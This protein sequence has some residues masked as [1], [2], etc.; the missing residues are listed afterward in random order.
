MMRSEYLG[1]IYT[2]VG[3]LINWLLGIKEVFTRLLY[4]T[5]VYICDLYHLC[6]WVPRGLRIAH[7]LKQ[8][9]FIECLPYAERGKGFASVLL[10]RRLPSLVASSPP[11]PPPVPLLPF[12]TD[13]GV[14]NS[15]LQVPGPDPSSRR[16]CG[17]ATLLSPSF[18]H[19]G[20]KR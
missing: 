5:P 17:R 1:P 18:L 3:F 15:F 9:L 12:P 13:L 7:P 8:Q 4:E 11:Q 6:M 19:E 10:W 2:V 14:F 16:V 20:P